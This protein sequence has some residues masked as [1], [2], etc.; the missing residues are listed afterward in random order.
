MTKIKLNQKGQG[1]VEYLILVALIAVG[2]IAVV[3]TL[4]EN[5]NNRFAHIIKSMGGK[6]KDEIGNVEFDKSAYRK[7]D[8]SNF[9]NNGNGTKD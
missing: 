1:L 4:G 8:L 5:I 9:M 2:S 6:P 7:R 3:S